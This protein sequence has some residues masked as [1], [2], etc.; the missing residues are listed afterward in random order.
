MSIS[1]NEALRDFSERYRSPELEI[2]DVSESTPKDCCLSADFD[3]RRTNPRRILLARGKL[4]ASHYRQRLQSDEIWS[5]VDFSGHNF[6]EEST[7]SVS[8]P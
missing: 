7:A 6:P 1:K 8:R 2:H 5:F 3:A 4:N